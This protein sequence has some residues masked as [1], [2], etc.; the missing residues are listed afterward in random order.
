MKRE[1]ISDALNLLDARHISDTIVFSPG[2]IQGSGE[3]MIHMKKKKMISIALAAVLMLSLGITAY[4]ILGVPRSTGTHLMPKTG[5][6]TSL[7]EL[8]KIEKDVGYPVTVPE[9]FSNGYAFH[10]LRVDGEA[11][12]GES[13]EVLKEYYAVRVSYQKD[14][15]PELT[16][17]LV[18]EIKLEGGSEAPAPSEE[19]S[20]DG[21]QVKLNRDHYK[22]VPEDYKKTEEDLSREAAGHYYVSFGSDEIQ[23][24]ETASA[25]F[26][27]DGVEY[28]LMDLSA[29]DD[30]FDAL[31]QMAAETIQKA[32]R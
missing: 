29:S 16:L 11:V 30:S 1:T 10:S 8:A 20:A 2:S 5:E 7:S 27:L 4:A 21:V 31:T 14:G 18:P 23:E 24:F 9:Q 22:A 13:N 3:R 26:V 17:H 12:F 32:K 6:Y 28:V 15:A 19:R 25:S